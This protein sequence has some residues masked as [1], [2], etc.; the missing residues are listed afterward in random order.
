MP[1][2]Q[3]ILQR[4]LAALRSER[5]LSAPQSRAAFV[6]S[7][8]RTALLGG[9]VQRCP[10]GHVERVWYN[11]CRHRSCPQCNALSRE[12]GLERMRSRLLD[13]AHHH[14]VFT[15]DH[16]LNALWMLNTATMMAALFGTVRDTLGTL[17]AGPR[18]LGAQPGMLLAL[19]TW[20]RSL[21][22]HP[23]I[24]ALVTDRG[25]SGERRVSPRRSHFLPA[26]ASE[27]VRSCRESTAAIGR[28]RES[29]GWCR[30]VCSGPW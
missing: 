8:C 13:C 3:H 10:E 26:R 6:L 27:H 24:H 28:H 21:A 19:H 12:R 5:K 11:S 16:A 22:L 14:L 1:S 4:H 25:W 2:V 9:H 20:G 29:A 30:C 7:A 15:I 23:Y 18:C 17:L